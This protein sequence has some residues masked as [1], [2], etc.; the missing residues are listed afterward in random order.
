[1]LPLT[2]LILCLLSFVNYRIGARAAFYPPVVFC[3][4]WAA[5]LGIL[6]MARDIFYPLSPETL[7]IFAGGC[8]AFSVGSLLALIYPFKGRKEEILSKASNRAL[9]CLLILI[10]GCIPFFASWIANLASTY[11]NAATFL[12]GVRRAI[13]D[14]TVPLSTTDLL[15]MNIATLAL[16]VAMISLYEKQQGKR[17][18]VIAIIAAL[19]LNLLTATRAATVSLIF[20]LICVDWIRSRHI[21]WKFVVMMLLVFIA[22][23]SV[24]AIELQKGDARAD[25]SISENI[26]PIVHSFVEYTCG[27]LIAFD[28]VVRNPSIIAHNWQVNRPFLQTLN[29]FGTQFE[30]PALHAEYVDVGYNSFP[31]NVYTAY[32][33]YLD[34][35]FIGMMGVICLIGLVATLF[36][37]AA[38][39]G[40]HI[41]ALMY[42]VLFAGIVLSIFNEGLLFNLNF[43]V[44][45]YAILW[46]FYRAPVVFSTSKSLSDG[47]VTRTCAST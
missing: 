34:L 25:A 12:M 28:R 36:Y 33:A 10:V 24:I 38:I 4:I 3:S 39:C 7:S 9:T 16:M 43:L 29:K 20:S 21:R 1:M 46:L 26:V 31:Q 41:S 5:D 40:S 8:V 44:K 13:L 47:R 17:R 45:L 14:D 27:G 23:F 18:F 22:A 11:G 42:S 2:V 15:F 19:V 6:W 30:I 32:F 35:G 37:K